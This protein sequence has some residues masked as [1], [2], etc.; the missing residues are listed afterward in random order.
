MWWLSKHNIPPQFQC[1]HILENG[2][3]CK[4][5]PVRG[6]NKCYLHDGVKRDVYTTGRERNKT[7]F[8]IHAR[9]GHTLFED[10]EYEMKRMLAVDI[11]KFTEDVLDWFLKWFN[12]KKDGTVKEK[13]D[14]VE[15]AIDMFDWK[16]YIRK[17]TVEE[18]KILGKIFKIDFPNSK[19]QDMITRLSVYLKGYYPGAAE[20]YNIRNYNN[21]KRAEIAK[22]M[23]NNKNSP[24]KENKKINLPAKKS[25]NSPKKKASAPK[26]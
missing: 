10:E 3:R 19:K 18:L 1:I 21:A 23:K 5:S 16:A 17:S 15:D 13:R 26:S 9:N 20:T 12:L 4:N 24:K 14:R 7:L 2:E 6:K 11:D 25:K 8:N 22:F